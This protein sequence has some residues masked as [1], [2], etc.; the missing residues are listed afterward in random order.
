VSHSRAKLVASGTHSAGLPLLL[1][2][3]LEVDVGRKGAKAGPRQVPDIGS[4][5]RL[6]PTPT[7]SL[8]A[9]GNVSRSAGCPALTR[10]IA[11]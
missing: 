1:Q 4:P 5:I 7:V 2:L 8:I 9:S 11:R 6:L 3:L 10:S